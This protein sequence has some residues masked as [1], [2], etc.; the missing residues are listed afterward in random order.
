MHAMQ[1]PRPIGSGGI[2]TVIMTSAIFRLHGPGNVQI[3]EQDLDLS[4]LASGDVA[5]RTLF[6]AVSAGTELAAYRGDPPLRPTAAPYPRLVGYCNVAEVVAVGTGV[7][8]FKPGDQVLSGQSHRSAF[9]CNE[10][11]IYVSLPA[12]LDPGAASV[13]YLFHLGYVSLQSAGLQSGQRVT[14]IGLGAVGL[15]TVACAHA[16]GITAGAI[17]N[18]PAS[19][20][21]AREWGADAL[22]RGEAA[23]LEAADCVVLT[24]CRWE[25]WRLALET[26]S[27]GGTIAVLG[28]PGRGQGLPDFNPLDSRWLY[29]KRLTIKS[30]GPAASDEQLRRNLAH[31][32]ELMRTHRLDAGPLISEMIPWRQLPKWYATMATERGDR[33]TAVLR[34]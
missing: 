6:T 14:V 7:A 29:D 30:T 4:R 5:A 15:G 21:L 20:A 33:L 23:G 9:I 25:D 2:K 17:S 13:V 27:S 12:G 16:M 3:E 18:Q 31:L 8:R 19:L 11:A 10:S 22:A 32:L 28:F 24:S 34:W 1:E 26:V